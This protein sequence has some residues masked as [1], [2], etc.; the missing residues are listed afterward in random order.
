MNV[1]KERITELHRKA[2]VFDFVPL[3]EPFV[4]TDRQSKVMRSALE[5][6]LPTPQVLRRMM[7][8]RLDE[9]ETNVD[10]REKIRAAWVGSGVNGVQVTLGGIEFNPGDWNAILRDI[11]HWYRRVCVSDDMSICCSVDD[12]L[13]AAGS[14]RV[15]LVLGLQDASAIEKEIDRLQVLKNFGVRVIQLTFNHR[16]Y[17]GDGCTE[18]EQS[19]LST[20]GVEVVK[21]MNELGIIVDVS[22]SGSRTTLDAIK[23]SSCPIAIT[24]SS[25]RS[26]TDHPRAKSD[27]ELRALRDGDGY[28]G[29]LAVPFFLKPEGGAKLQT[30]V[31]HV[32]HA[33]N[34]VGIDRVGIGTD[35][36][37]WCAD[38]PNEIKERARAQLAS[39]GFSKKELPEFGDIIPELDSWESWPN[40]TAALMDRGYSDHEVEGIVGGNWLKFMSRSCLR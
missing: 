31:Q 2:F 28:F 22:H 11:A 32:E 24:H 14:N 38:F 19:G 3:G 25:C 13:L 36:G 17:I 33:A 18:R 15:G 39:H 27:D 10:V 23:V 37:P 21:R 34:I 30:I 7:N 6:S 5:A 12:L 1:S 40:I 20:Y 29:V 16:N 9:L 8:D 26:I 4:M 35:W